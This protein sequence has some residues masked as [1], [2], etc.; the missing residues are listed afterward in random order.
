VRHS[1]S[2]ACVRQYMSMARTCMHAH[3]VAHVHTRV[4]AKE[5][6]YTSAHTARTLGV[7]SLGHRI[8]RSRDATY[9]RG[10]KRVTDRA[11][12]RELPGLVRPTPCFHLSLLHAAAGVVVASCVWRPCRVAH[13][14][15][16]TMLR[17]CCWLCAARCL[18][19]TECGTAVCFPSQL[20]CVSTLHASSCMS[21]DICCL[22]HSA[23]CLLVAILCAMAVACC[24]LLSACCTR[25]VVC[26][27][28]RC[29]MHAAIM[30]AA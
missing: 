7:A 2:H 9:R 27:C 24:T 12:V 19:R 17:A 15:S 29:I 5:D 4:H 6:T 11:P 21:S 10:G 30:H 14:L 28:V 16:S 18:P 8:S 20:A 22:L 3:M 25:S 13:W 26:C 23:R 1:H